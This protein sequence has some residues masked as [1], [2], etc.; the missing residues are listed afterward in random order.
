MKNRVINIGVVAEIAEALKEFKDQVIFV[1]G[2]VVS[3]YTDDP[4]ADDI[5]PTADIDITVKL[6][7]QGNYLQIQKHLSGLGFKLDMAGHSV[8]SYKYKDIPVDIM[9]TEDML[10]I[11]S[12]K[13]FKLGLTTLQT[14]Q[15][16]NID[17]QILSAPYFLATK[18][19]AFNDRSAD[20]R[21]SHDIEDVIYILD[22]RINIANEINQADLKVKEFIKSE[23]QKIIDN[24]ALEEIIAAHVHPLVIEQRQVIIMDKLTQILTR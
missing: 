22:N 20:Y 12:T 9:S 2:S 18:F 16:N 15:A 7:N 6:M 10:L 24:N 8:C 21:T 3:L 13:W 11:P 5:R 1:G 17:I 19:K 23:F 4:A 14:V